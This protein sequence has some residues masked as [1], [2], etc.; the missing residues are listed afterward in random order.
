MATKMKVKRT[1]TYGT[2]RD[3]PSFSL[4]EGRLTEK[5]F[6]RAFKAEG[7]SDGESCEIEYKWLKRVNRKWAES[8]MKDL[9]AKIY[10]V[11]YW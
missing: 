5:Q 8:D 11:T 2:D 7:W 4:V 3:N 10:T 6:A 9:K 1:R